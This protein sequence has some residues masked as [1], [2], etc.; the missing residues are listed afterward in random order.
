[1]IDQSVTTPQPRGGSRTN[2]PIRH[3]SIRVTYLC[4]NSRVDRLLLGSCILSEGKK[5]RKCRS[6]GTY[7]EQNMS[8]SLYAMRYDKLC[9]LRCIKLF[10][11]SAILKNFSQNYH[12]YYLTLQYQLLLI[13]G[14]KFRRRCSRVAE[15]LMDSLAMRWTARVIPFQSQ[16]QQTSDIVHQRTGFYT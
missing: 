14:P 15:N 12:P 6:R 5:D 16:L 9:E 3:K 1:L 13:D 2:N 7:L 8:K 11:G 4:V 10:K